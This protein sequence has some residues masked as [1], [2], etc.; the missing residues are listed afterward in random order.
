MVGSLAGLFVA[1]LVSRLMIGL[2][3]FLPGEEMSKSPTTELPYLQ[4]CLILLL[5]LRN[6]GHMNIQFF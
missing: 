2:S 6:F 3:Q 1:L 5:S 4:P